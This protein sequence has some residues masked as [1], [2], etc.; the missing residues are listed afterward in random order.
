MQFVKQ[1][2]H[3]DPEINISGDQA[4]KLIGRALAVPYAKDYKD[5]QAMVKRIGSAIRMGHGSVLEHANIT[6]DV[7]TSIEVYKGFTRHRHCVF[8]IESTAFVKYDELTFM[9]EPGL[10]MCDSWGHIEEA[11]KHH[12]SR[13]D[14]KFARSLLPQGTAARMVMTTNVREYRHIIGLRG[15]PG[16]NRTNTELRNLIWAE[17]NKWSPILFPMTKLDA[18]KD[19]WIPKLWGQPVRD[20]AEYCTI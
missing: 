6:L 2:V 17:L 3:L 11:Y 13:R 7:V 12:S 8:T 15:D 10:E 5:E 20:D 4:I 1:A 16:D 14:T 9:C 18:P 19:F